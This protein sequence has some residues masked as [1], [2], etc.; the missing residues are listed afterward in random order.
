MADAPEGCDRG[1]GDRQDTS[2]LL[3]REEPGGVQGGG[4]EMMVQGPGSA[5]PSRPP[6]LQPGVNRSHRR[7]HSKGQ[8]GSGFRGR[9]ALPSGFKL[10]CQLHQVIV[11]R[12]ADDDLIIDF[13]N[14]VRCLIRLETLFS[15][16]TPGRTRVASR[17]PQAVCP[18]GGGGKPSSWWGEKRRRGRGGLGDAA[19]RGEGDRV[20]V[21]AARSRLT[22]ASLPPQG[23]LSSWTPRT[24]APYSSTLSL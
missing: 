8:V 3:G 17:G 18:S 7:C 22:P 13:D 9:G 23:Y 24:R 2:S 16:W 11:A 4:L 20:P 14:F 6:R 10:P 12:F 5:K 1:K 19:A 21:A 15:K